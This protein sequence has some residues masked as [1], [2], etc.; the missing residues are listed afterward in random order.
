MASV[1]A[2]GQSSSAP[3]AKPQSAPATQNPATASADT[4]GFDTSVDPCM[5]FY[6]YVCNPWRKANP[7]PGDQSTW[8]SFDELE[9]RND[10]KLRDILEAA[11]KDTPQRSPVQ[12]KI[13]DYYAA[14]IDDRAID[15]RG[16]KPLDAEF[17][18]IA[19]LSSKSEL[20]AEIA[21]LHLI[22]FNLAPSTDSGTPTALFAF[23]SGQDFDDAT[24]VVA[25]VDQGGISLPDRD[26][27]L[28]TDPESQGLLNRFVTHVTRML[29]VTGEPQTRAIPDAKTVVGIETDLAKASMDIVQRRDPANLNHKMSL[30]ELQALTPSFSWDDYLKGVGAPPSA[31]YIVTSP[32]FLKGIEAEIKKV[33][34]DNWKE[35]LKWQ[36]V[37]ASAPM[38]DEATVKQNWHFFNHTLLGEQ[39]PRERWRRCVARVDTDLGEALGQAYVEQNFSPESKQRVLTMLQAIENSVDTDIQQLDWMTPATKK[40]AIVKLHAIAKNIGYPDRWRDYSS[41]KIL[42]SDALGNVYRS[43]EFELHRQLAKIGKP[44]DRNEWQM[45]PPTVNAYYNPQLNSIN[46]P[47]GILQPPFFRPT[48]D[49]ATNFGAIGQVIGHEITHG[50][51]DEGRKFDPAGNVH[52]WWTPE[53]AKQFETRAKCIENEYSAFTPI[54][55]VHVNGALTLGENTADNGGLRLSYMALMDMLSKAGKADAKI[56]GFTPAQRFFFSFAKIYCANETTQ[57]LRVRLASN[58]HSPMPY[59]VNGVVQNM[60]EFQKAFGCKAG[61]DMVRA[62]A[63][64]VW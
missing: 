23:S 60:P 8:S 39:K 57:R 6:A 40:E 64:R 58:P 35:Y 53:D 63:C 7:L 46:F 17:E 18:R 49:D 22:T 13:G 42:R 15:E 1:C 14:C 27:Y 38:L 50:F 20:A 55:D 29:I 24:K 33:T 10:K 2:Y 25:V 44:V 52:D 56:D 4:S 61:Q 26:Y 47:A 62:P 3:T 12:Q 5:N 45:T 21:H 37:R 30:A 9:L 34:L 19:N 11:Q 43:S 28:K 31:H 51:D 36:L 59:R 16:L 32:E 48:A 41:L 54:P